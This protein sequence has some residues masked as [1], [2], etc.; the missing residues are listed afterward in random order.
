MIKRLDLYK[1]KLAIL[2]ALFVVLS[3]DICSSQ[4][5][6]GLDALEQISDW[7]VYRQ[8][9]QSLQVSSYDQTGGDSDHS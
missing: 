9:V 5:V 7:P 6:T 2:M 8:G 3:G 1:L 4:A